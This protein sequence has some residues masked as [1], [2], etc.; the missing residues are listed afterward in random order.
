MWVFLQP[1]CYHLISFCFN[2]SALPCQKTGIRRS[3]QVIK[4]VVIDTMILKF[5]TEA[6]S[7]SLPMRVVSGSVTSPAIAALRRE[8]RKRAF[9]IGQSL[10][11]VSDDKADLALWILQCNSCHGNVEHLHF[12]NL[13]CHWELTKFTW[14]GKL[15]KLH[16]VILQFFHCPD[17]FLD[18]IAKRANNSRVIKFAELDFSSLSLFRHRWR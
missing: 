5:M 1:L 6:H 9:S 13:S 17:V 8:T 16:L 10:P 11:A 4:C 12:G 14:K 18:T 7:S 15:L 2:H 3:W